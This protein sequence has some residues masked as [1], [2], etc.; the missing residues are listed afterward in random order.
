[1]DMVGGW[2]NPSENYEFVNWDDKIPNIWKTNEKIKMS[3]TT[4]QYRRFAH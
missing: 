3:Q 2:T 1:M 4:N